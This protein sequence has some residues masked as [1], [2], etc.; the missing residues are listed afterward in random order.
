MSLYVN[1]NSIYQE[2]WLIMEL[3]LYTNFKKKYTNIRS[4]YIDRRE[5]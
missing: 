5:E 3:I 2:K 1:F 4:N